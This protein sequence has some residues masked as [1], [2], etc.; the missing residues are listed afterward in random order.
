MTEIHTLLLYGMGAGWCLFHLLLY[1]LV[2]RERPCF[3]G[4]RQIFRY[5]AGSACLYTL[6]VLT[7]VL[8][9]RERHAVALAV[10]LVAAHGI[11]S[12]SFLELWSLAQG[13]YS[14]RVL[15]GVWARPE[16]D[17]RDIVGHFAALGD[18]KKADRLAALVHLGL[19]RRSDGKFSLTGRGRCVAALVRSLQWLPNLKNTG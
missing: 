2:L 6:L 13:S 1:I 12:M 16:A 10:G 19:V 4:E 7:W 5:H 11:Y 17:Q 3:Y 14:L 15:E 8:V 18:A 9:G